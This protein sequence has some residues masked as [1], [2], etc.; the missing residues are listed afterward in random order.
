MG[1]GIFFSFNSIPQFP[2]QNPYNINNHRPC[3]IEAGHELSDDMT[4]NNKARETI[5]VSTSTLYTLPNQKNTIAYLTTL[6]GSRG[7][8]LKSH[9]R[10]LISIRETLKIQVLDLICWW[11][12]KVLGFWL[13]LFFVWLVGEGRAWWWCMVYSG[14]AWWWWIDRWW[15]LG[16]CVKW[17]QEKREVWRVK[18]IIKIVKE[19]LFYWIKV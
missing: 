16:L 13:F 19:W 4:T 3:F 8:R 6:E 15:W 18:E 2:N 11:F 7:K 5:W 1:F 14:C 9:A 12:L 17:F 10:L